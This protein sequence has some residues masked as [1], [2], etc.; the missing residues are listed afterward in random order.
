MIE[1]KKIAKER[2]FD[3]YCV[4]IQESNN[5]Y[6]IQNEL[7]LAWSEGWHEAECQIEGADD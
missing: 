2:G 4:G 7:H 5:P 3:A 1:T 6:D